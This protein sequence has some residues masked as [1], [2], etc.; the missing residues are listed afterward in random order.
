MLVLSRKLDESIIIDDN[1]RITV[2]GI[3][4]NQVRLGIQAPPSI[5]VFRQ[6]ILERAGRA[7]ERP[8]LAPSSTDSTRAG[9]SS[10]Y[11]AEPAEME[12]AS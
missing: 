3:R 12:C 5:G 11:L 6:E 4:G 9:P 2:V 1:I 7:F 8:A 10:A